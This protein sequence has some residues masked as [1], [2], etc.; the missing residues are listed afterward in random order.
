[1]VKRDF[2]AV[3]GSSARLNAD[4][5]N[6]YP[7]VLINGVGANINFT[8]SGPN[9]DVDTNA[10]LVPD[11][12]LTPAGGLTERADNL[13]NG[14]LALDWRP[15]DG[16]LVYGSWSRGT[17]SGGFNNGFVTIGANSEVPFGPEAVNAFELGSKTTIGTVLRVAA[18]VY[19][20]RF[21]GYQ[22]VAFQG[23]GTRTLNRD[24]RV[25]GAEVEFSAFP[26]SGL[27]AQGTVSLL[28]TEV[29]G[30]NNGV[31]VFD[32]EMGLAPELS[33]KGLLRYNRL[34]G[35]GQMTVQGDGYWAAEQFADVMNQPGLTVPAHM[36]ANARV[37]YSRGLW[38]LSAWVHNLTN[39]RIPNARYNLGMGSLMTW[40]R[41]PRWYGAGLSLRW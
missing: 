34:V 17:K 13:V 5:E 20:Y 39:E 30:I 22:A 40:Y 14:K 9:L 21:D 10:D 12:T 19:H 33:I 28:R 23:L 36:F 1:M 6:L 37:G 29:L 2:V 31:T 4:W 32:A 35:A 7:G 3:P 41:P 26:M 24:A 8:R 38:E 27:E 11:L 16:L 25:S 15:R 18:A